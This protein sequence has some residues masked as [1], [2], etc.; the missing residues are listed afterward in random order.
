M[1]AY[2]S[3]HVIGKTAEFPGACPLML[4]AK[5]CNTQT[6]YCAVGGAGAI[7]FQSVTLSISM[8]DSV[9]WPTPTRVWTKH[10]YP[11]HY[12]TLYSCVC[13]SIGRAAGRQVR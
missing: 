8:S 12:F 13:N 7:G 10:A 6:M 2:S 5:G 1:Y 11:L 3:S 9:F 4:H